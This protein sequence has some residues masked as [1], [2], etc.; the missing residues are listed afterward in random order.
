M[1]KIVG[2]LLIAIL[3][4][5]SISACNKPEAVVNDNPEVVAGEEEL[6]EAKVYTFGF[7]CITMDNPYFIA[8]EKALKDSLE[9][10]GH[11]LI[12]KDAKSDCMLQ[13]E[14]IDDLIEAEVD[15]VF[16]APVDWIEIEPSLDKLN[17]AGIPI[18]NLDTQVQAFDKIDAYVGSNNSKAGYTCGKDLLERIPT[19]GKII[20]VECPN[21]NSINERIKGFE[22]AIAKK[23]FEVVARID[24]K[25][26]LDVALPEV[27]A[28]LRA[29]PDVVAI[30]CGNDPTAIGAV[31]AANNVGTRD[32]IIYGIDG[33]PDVK[34]EIAKEG[35]L[36]VATVAQSTETI[37]KEAVSVTLKMLA[38]E[39]YKA[40]TYIDTFFITKDNIAEY[41]INSWQ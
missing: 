29:N 31:V 3:C 28:A 15:A 1:R 18:I 38:D 25:G 41:D 24:A 14:Q 12:T 32:L 34:K 19:G 16:V 22:R 36:I 33:S 40:I 39:K 11:T 27:E 37:G 10:E 17:D 21:R 8:L 30:M 23:G 26:D 6:E 2:V 5:F 13:N 9:A 35:S 20:L 7:S 4:I